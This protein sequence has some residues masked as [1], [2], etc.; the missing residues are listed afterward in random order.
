MIR[1]PPSNNQRIVAN[2]A[3]TDAHPDAA[4]LFELMRISSND[5][6]AQ[7]LR[8]R[9][10]EDSAMVLDSWEKLVRA[11]ARTIVPSQTKVII[12]Q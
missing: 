8:M 11:G 5:I 7:N 4:R 12:S 10:G 3:F 1:H 6:S 2:M 9:D